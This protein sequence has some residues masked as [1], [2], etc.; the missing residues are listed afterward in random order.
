MSAALATPVVLL[1]GVPMLQ[2]AFAGIQSVG[3]DVREAKLHSVL[4]SE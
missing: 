3:I 2:V 1:L 4:L